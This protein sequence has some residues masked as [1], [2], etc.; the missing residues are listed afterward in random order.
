MSD[1]SEYI[2][3]SA[4]KV[5]RQ[6]YGGIFPEQARQIFGDRETT[7]EDVEKVRSL[8]LQFPHGLLY[9][10]EQEYVEAVD[11]VANE[12]DAP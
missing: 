4:S 2:G 10:W 9:I 5:L 12:M 7:A 8:G 1:G 11:E 3:S 6:V